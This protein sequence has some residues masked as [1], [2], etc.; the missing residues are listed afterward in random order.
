MFPTSIFGKTELGKHAAFTHATTV[1]ISQLAPHLSYPL[2]PAFN[3]VTSPKKTLFCPSLIYLA[4]FLPVQQCRTHPVALHR[5]AR[6]RTRISVSSQQ[7]RM[8]GGGN[9][10]NVLHMPTW[11]YTLFMV[12]CEERYLLF[13]H[14]IPKFTFVT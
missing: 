6:Q 3:N 14:D 9:N 13:V 8:G 5:Y 12:Y 4:H 1:L 10:H 11:Y 7:S 2:Y